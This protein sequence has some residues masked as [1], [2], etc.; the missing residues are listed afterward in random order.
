MGSSLCVL[1]EILFYFPFGRGISVIPC[2]LLTLNE[3]C[4][5][6]LT[7]VKLRVTVGVGGVIAV[8]GY[9]GGAVWKWVIFGVDV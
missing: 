2:T 6:C 7:G 1:T 5:F 8:R 4:C 3:G 9:G